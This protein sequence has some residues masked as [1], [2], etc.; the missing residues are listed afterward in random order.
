[1]KKFNVKDSF[2][3]QRFVRACFSQRRKKLI[4]SLKS[5][6]SFPIDKLEKAF[7]EA[8]IDPNRRAET[9]SIEEFITLSEIFGKILDDIERR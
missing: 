4:N 3:L 9:L 6:S 7:V 1:M 2:W 5:T 8:N